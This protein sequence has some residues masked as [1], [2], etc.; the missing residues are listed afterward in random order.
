[1]IARARMLCVVGILL[2]GALGLISATQTWFHVMLRGAADSDVTVV[3]TVA[4]PVMLPLALACLALAIVLAIV[5]PVMRFV[6]AGIGLV[7][8]LTLTV[9]TVLLMVQHPVSAVASVVTEKTGIAGSDSVTDLVE[10][11]DLTPWPVVALIAWLI[12]TVAAMFALL[13][14]RRWTRSGRR[15]STGAKVV[16]EGPLDAV[17]S[18]DDLSRGEDPTH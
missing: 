17:D 16:H 9:A 13:T 18:W 3:G 2:G 8:G 5:G 7:I 1:M 12:I 11:M 10:R 6:F 14:A 4:L 15:Y